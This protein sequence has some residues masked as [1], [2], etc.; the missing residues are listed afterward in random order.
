MITVTVKLYAYFRKDRK[1]VLQL[2]LPS[3]AKIINIL[4]KL[5]IPI[6]EVGVLILRD[7]N[8]VSL[9]TPLHDRDIVTLIPVLG[10]G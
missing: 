5:N 6:E 10:G 7:Q 9:K 4:E 8:S 3:E 1:P 2:K